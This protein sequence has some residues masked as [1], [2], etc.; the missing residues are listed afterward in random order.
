M[1][2]TVERDTR[3]LSPNSRSLNIAE[4]TDLAVGLSLHQNRRFHIPSQHWIRLQRSRIDPTARKHDSRYLIVG[5]ARVRV[6][7]LHW[8]R[9]RHFELAIPT[10]WLPN[11]LAASSALN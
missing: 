10:S 2:G 9:A 11:K 1:T 7:L 4:L 8:T 5:G 6:E 3:S